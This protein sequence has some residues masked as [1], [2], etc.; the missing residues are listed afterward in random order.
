[1]NAPTV[2][3]TAITTRISLLPGVE[4]PFAAWQSKFTRAAAET[5]GFLTL[6][7][8]PARAGSPD[9]Q[10]I[11]RFR[12][13][14]QLGGWQNAPQR[15]QMLAE[16]AP[17]RQPGVPEANDEATPA[18]DPLSCVTEVIT[19]I[20]EAGKEHLFQTWAAGVQ[21]SQ[22][23]FPGYVGMLIQAPVSADIPYWTTLVRFSTPALLDAW[24][25]SADRK[26]LLQQAD[27]AVARWQS[28]RLPSPFAGWFP[29]AEGR[30]APPAWKQTTLV[31]LV[32]FPVVMLE[33]AFLSPYLA[34]QH[35]AIA[36][37]IGNAI[38]VSLVSWP[39]MK[40]AVFCMGWWLQPPPA[41]RWRQEALGVCTMLGLYAVELLIFMLLY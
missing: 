9:W 24:L 6:E 5:P 4:R 15:R 20:V 37:F 35:L 38:S 36:T 2:P 29:I 1:M 30:P 18:L 32:L 39:L 10:I 40:I 23:T 33:I 26:M 12:S 25:G 3:V 28:H 8:A 27:P 22:A 34:G 11:Q 16:L 7:I 14:G 21:A 41:H 17:L 13:P 19:T 31:L